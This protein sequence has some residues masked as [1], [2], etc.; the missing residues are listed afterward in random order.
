MNF[1]VTLCGFMGCGKSRLGKLIAQQRSIPFIDLDEIIQESEG[2]SIKEIFD[3]KGEAYFRALE[4]RCLF[5]Q[6]E[7]AK[8]SNQD[9]ILSLGG[10]ALVSND[11]IEAIKKL[12]ILSYIKVPFDELY[13][14]L[15]RRTT[16]PLLLDKDGNLKPKEQ[17]YPFLLELYESRLPLYEQADVIFASDSRFDKETNADN[18]ATHIQNHLD[19]HQIC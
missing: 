14:R 10:G 2:R 12:S 3:L 19:N 7:M 5:E 9:F 8:V 16:R 1:R 6:L 15:I 4:E 18:L 17:L 11:R 13:E